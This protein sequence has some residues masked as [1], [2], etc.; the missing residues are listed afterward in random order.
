[1]KLSKMPKLRARGTLELDDDDF[2]LEDSSV[3][4]VLRK[5]AVPVLELFFSSKLLLSGV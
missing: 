4:T 1:M 2:E 5:L 3:P